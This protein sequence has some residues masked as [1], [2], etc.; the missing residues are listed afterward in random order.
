MKKKNLPI[1]E[2]NDGTELEFDIQG[3]ITAPQ[4]HL[5]G[6]A[7]Y[8]PEL[9]AIHKQASQIKANPWPDGIIVTEQ[10]DFCLDEG[11]DLADYNKTEL[12]DLLDSAK[13]AQ[14]LIQKAL[15]AEQKRRPEPGPIYCG[16]N[17]YIKYLQQVTG[18]F[19]TVHFVLNN[20]GQRTGADLDPEDYDPMPPAG[21]V[22]IGCKHVPYSLLCKALK[23]AQ[24]IRAHPNRFNH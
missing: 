13:A 3:N 10:A 7:V 17:Q 23:T 19:Y 6:K 20:T 5:N 16:G 1:I 8:Y 4:Q 21:D 14:V 22:F 24:L 12:T 18:K 9:V 11:T 2:L 15:K